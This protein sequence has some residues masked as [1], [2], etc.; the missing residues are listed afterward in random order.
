MGDCLMLTGLPVWPHSKQYDRTLLTAFTPPF[1]L[2]SCH[3]FHTVRL[4]H[5]RDDI[6]DPGGQRD[7]CSSVLS[8]QAGTQGLKAC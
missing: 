6:C 8:T 5:M 3:H 7:T 1:A 2:H 4:A